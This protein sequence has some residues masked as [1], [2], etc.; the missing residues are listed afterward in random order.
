MT[1]PRVKF[2]RHTVLLAAAAGISCNGTGTD[3]FEFSPEALQSIVDR[4]QQWIDQ[5][6][7]V[8]A[9]LLMVQGGEVIL[10]EA[11]GWKD[12]EREIA[13]EPNTVFN[14]QSMTK[15]V[16]STA[17][18]MLVEE[19]ALSLSDRAAAYLPSF[20]NDRSG[21]ITILQLLTRTAGFTQASYPASITSYANLRAAVDDL[22]TVG[23]ASPPGTIFARRVGVGVLGAIVEVVTG[24]PV[25][26]FIRN[27]ILD[28]LGMTDNTLT[29]LLLDDPIRPRVSSRYYRNEA[30]VFD[31]FWDNRD[32]QSLDFFP[33]SGGLYSTTK[34]YL[35]F[36][37]LWMNRGRL[38]NQQLLSEDL[39]LQALQI[40]PLTFDALV[41][42]GMLWEVTVD[43]G[44][45]NP[46]AGQ[47]LPSFG[48]RGIDGTMGWVV[49]EHELV[50]LYFTQSRF[51][52]THNDIIQVVRNAIN[53]SE[54]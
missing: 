25:E 21:D 30:G 48:H 9:E 28:P 51:G 17:V 1:L 36:L 5:G 13:M 3:N 33:A 2:T 32:P 40:H 10:H 20:D 38:G 52:T 37:T 31:K 7:T 49:P 45:M 4:V 6:E 14:I 8:G 41:P 35:K 11:R 42:Y 12:R 18:L 26:V 27:R 47:S 39:V 46:V 50:V 16:T 53:A 44:A 22:G 29:E 19:G 15:P 43:A 34:D 24:T 23:P 54:N